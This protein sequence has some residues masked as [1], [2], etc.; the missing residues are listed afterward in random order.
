MALY[1][2]IYF[3]L[4][5]TVTSEK[6]FILVLDTTASMQEEVDII[7]ANKQFA[8]DEKTNAEYILLP[9]NN[10]DVGPPLVF[11]T[12]TNFIDHLDLV[13][14]GGGKGCPEKSL[15]A[16]EMALE[17]SKYSSNIYVFTDAIAKSEERP[18]IESISQLC[19]QKRS[20]VFIFQSGKCVSESNDFYYEVASLCSG[21]VFNFELSSLKKAFDFIR[22][23]MRL[24]W[25]P[26]NVQEVS[27]NVFGQRHY[28]FTVDVLTS[29]I[30]VGVSGHNPEVQISN[31]LGQIVDYNTIMQTKN[32]SVMCLH[33]LENGEYTIELNSQD[34]A[35]IYAFTHKQLAFKYGFS[36]KAPRSLKETSERPIPGTS[37]NIL[38]VT[39]GT[40]I[41]VLSI[42]VLMLKSGETTVLN[43]ELSYAAKGHY[44]ATHLFE[45]GKSFRLSI[46]AKYANYNQVISGASKVIET[47]HQGMVTEWVNP[48]THIIDED[49]NLIGFGVNATFACK[50]DS[51]PKPEVWWEDENSERLPSDTVLLEIPSTYI[52]YVSID[53]ATHNGTITC[54]AKND[55]GTADSSMDVFVNRTFVFEVLEYPTDITVNYGDTGKLY[56][57][58]NA[59]PE[60]EIKWIHNGTEV[61]GERVEINSD[62][63]W[64]LIK[65]MDLDDV[66]EYVCDIQNEVES[67]TYTATVFI[68]G[69]EAPV[70]QIDKS[71]VILKPGD[72]TEQKCFITKG[73]PTP[74]ISWKY[75]LE[76]DFSFLEIPEGVYISDKVL[77]IPSAQSH[78]GGVY[79][80]EAN[81]SLG[82][83]QQQVLVK[84]QFQPRIK[85]QD[86]SLEVRQGDVV[87]LPCDVDAVPEAEVHWDM[88]QDDVIIAF[89]ERHHTDASYTHRFTAQLNDSGMY[90]CIAKNSM[91]TA[92]RTV[93]VNVWVAPYIQSPVSNNITQLIGTTLYLNCYIN[94]GNP[95]PSTRWEF[96]APNTNI[97]VLKTGHATGK[98]EY[99]VQDLKKKNEGTYRCI[100][101]NDVGVDS[102]NLFLKVV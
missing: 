85:N 73:K 55:L 65:N 52:S 30:L 68:T 98:L 8:L 88:Y 47:Q 3:G 9:F 15:S 42:E 56:C 60:A 48:S 80:C 1:S 77:K 22:E 61:D 19:R 37:N 78:H 54:K 66:G 14:A 11:T 20:Q 39:S 57:E 86:E 23:T 41:E 18:K 87:T 32:A 92:T 16:I 63:N 83:D 102:I 43:L 75:R 90:H 94:F 31:E 81:N 69:L 70:I 46:T 35:I 101:E 59:Y 5:Y 4:I 26:A 12:A 36:P 27:S 53:N 45:P 24:E 58:V 67:V 71:E 2:L 51:F 13:E 44:M 40:N 33:G 25:T 72:W 84:V 38:I 91:G 17:K 95:L 64:L 99:K 93:N 76:N 10:P 74:S 21:S 34:P 89:D 82:I 79:L 97:S 6:S 100:A 29:D 28:T 49:N 50:I 96:I 62:E 7:K